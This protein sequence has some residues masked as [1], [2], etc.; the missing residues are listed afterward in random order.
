L[1]IALTLVFFPPIGLILMWSSSGWSDDLK[2]GISGIFFPPL[3]LRFL[4]RIPWLAYAAMGGVAVLLVSAIRSGFPI[5]AAVA[6]LIAVVVF[7]L[8]L[9]PA[10]PAPRRK[11]Q[12]PSAELR[13]QIEAKVDA[14]NDLIADIEGTVDL[15]LLPSTSPWRRRYNRALEMRSTG[16]GLLDEGGNLW[17]A[18]QRLSEAL[19]ELRV[20]RKGLSEGEGS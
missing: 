5:V 1:W 11:A 4:W 20:V 17:A 6:I 7:L 10:Q 18:D 9:K 19:L 8:L 13:R 15:D 12:E 2:W 3:W 14:C 16:L